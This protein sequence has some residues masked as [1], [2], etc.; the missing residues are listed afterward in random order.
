MKAVAAEGS[1]ISVFSPKGGSGCTTIAINLAVS[2]AQREFRTLL[3][4]GSLQF[5]DVSVMVNMKPVTSIVD[6]SS[7]DGEIDSDLVNSVVQVHKS[8]LHVLMAPPRPEMADVV[9]DKSIKD[10]LVNLRPYMIL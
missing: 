7:R 3:I 10:L 8:G 5:G 4:D 9:T 1:V 2:L 6:F